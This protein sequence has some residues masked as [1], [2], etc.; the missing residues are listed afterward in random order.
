MGTRWEEF[1]WSNITGPNMI[2]SNAVAA[3]LDNKM[4]VIKV[5]LDL[6]WRCSMRSAIDSSFKERSNNR[7]V[8][9]ELIDFMDENPEQLEPGKFILNR[10]ASSTVK[11]GYREKSK[12]SVQEYISSK[13]IIKNRIIW[14]K[15]LD[16]L[17][18][19]KWIKFCRGFAERKATDGLFVIEVHP[20][21]VTTESELIKVIDFS[22]YVSSYDVQLFNSF[23]LDEQNYYTD[24]WKK[25][26]SACSASVCDID[27]E[28]SELLLR[29]VNF[30]KESISEGIRRIL[31]IS[32]FSRR[33]EDKSS[34]H[35]LWHFRNGNIAEINYRIW[36][37]QIQ[38]L[39][40]VIELERVNLIHKY[41]SEIQSVLDSNN[42]IQYGEY[43]DDPIDV[44]LGTLCYLMKKRNENGSYSLF[45][46]DE[47]DRNRIKFLH[48][49]RNKLAHVTCC[50]PEQ[51]F[52]LLC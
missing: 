33:G 12:V 22:D 2:V 51:V 42:V 28:I 43:L 20:D 25:Y 14:I 4:V 44:E 37:A 3:L 23:V 6:P 21:I 16:K 35:I 10:F 7:D 5:P 30:K 18:A 48:E 34:E 41:V 15:G 13:N 8:I 38:I 27:A 52:E 26:I 11:K 49:C 17:R 31:E 1:W 50:S 40:P 19:E 47:T 39:F 45:I 46:P 36:N 29:M 32:D 24:N 9:I